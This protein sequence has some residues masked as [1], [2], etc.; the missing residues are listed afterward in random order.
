MSLPKLKATVVELHQ[1][2]QRLDGVDPELRELLAQLDR[3]I[4]GLTD[5]EKTMSAQG[6]YA[7]QLTAYEAEFSA[8]HPQLAGMFRSLLETLHSIGI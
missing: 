3:D 7:S 8:G 5:P 4:H 6:D 2:L 1:A